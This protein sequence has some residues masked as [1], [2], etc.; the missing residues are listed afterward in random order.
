MTFDLPEHLESVAALAVAIWRNTDPSC[1]QLS[2]LHSGAQARWRDLVRDTFSA[3]EAGRTQFEG[4]EAAAAEAIRKWGAHLKALAVLPELERLVAD[5]PEGPQ[6][7]TGLL[8]TIGEGA[9]ADPQ[10]TAEVRPKRGRKK[11]D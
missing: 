2:R 9:P 7:M 3:L 11:S 1:A 8:I 10:V 5:V 4:Q 6:T